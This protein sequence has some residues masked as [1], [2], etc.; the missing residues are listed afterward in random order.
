MKPPF[1]QLN[2]FSKKEPMQNKD[3]FALAISKLL[4]ITPEAVV[5]FFQPSGLL[6]LPEFQAETPPALREWVE[7][8][9]VA[10][11]RLISTSILDAFRVSASGLR[12]N[13]KKG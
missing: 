1:L 4:D 2:L 9:D 13:F 11:A 6:A 8:W 3:T 7:G 10:R 12:K 5:T